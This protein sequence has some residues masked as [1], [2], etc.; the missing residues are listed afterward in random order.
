MQDSNFLIIISNI[1]S[2]LISVIC[3]EPTY[4]S[5]HLGDAKKGKSYVGGWGWLSI[6]QTAWLVKYDAYRDIELHKSSSVT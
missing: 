3:A 1:F 2:W 6:G 4:E 5:I